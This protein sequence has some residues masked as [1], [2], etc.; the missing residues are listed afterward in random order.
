MKNLKSLEK[1]SNKLVNAFLYNKILAPIPTKYVKSMKE[2]ERLRRLCES[3]V[4]Q[5]V[6]GFKACGTSIPMLK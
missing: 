4:K 2:A 3:K 1:L 6:I 5:P